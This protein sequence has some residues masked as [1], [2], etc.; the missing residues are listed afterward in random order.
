MAV[1]EVRKI[2]EKVDDLSKTPPNKFGTC[3]AC[4][5]VLQ[6]GESH[7]HNGQAAGELVQANIPQPKPFV[8]K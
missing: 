6:P 8:L 1:G 2:A 3:G 4:G 7:N 5:R